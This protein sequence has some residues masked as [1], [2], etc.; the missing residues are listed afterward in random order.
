MQ[1]LRKAGRVTYRPLI[2]RRAAARSVACLLV[3]IAFLLA[4]P[5]GPTPD[6]SPGGR[7][8]VGLAFAASPLE[9]C[10]LDGYDDHNGA[11]LPWA[12]FD[13]TRGDTIP[14]G[15]DGVANSW[16]GEHT[17]DG[18]SA[19]TSGNGSAGTKKPTT[20]GS[21]DP[22]N[23]GG[24]DA[25][26]RSGGSGSTSDSQ[27]GS[28][29]P[30]SGAPVVIGSPV[31]AGVAAASIPTTATV[32]GVRGRILV[33]DADGA[34]VHAGG[35]LRITGE[36]FHPS[37]DGFEI[38]LDN[39]RLE[40]KASTD[41]G[42]RFEVFVTLPRDTVPGAHRIGVSY[43]GSHLAHAPVAVGAPP[44]DTFLGALLV[45]LDRGNRDRDAGLST[46]LGLGLVGAVSYGWRSF[47]RRPSPRRR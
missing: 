7:F 21:S 18:G 25:A 12:G 16:K 15:W 42:G 1:D 45:G 43:G 5:I 37:V 10:D 19:G 9:D 24:G 13:S 46:L 14:S 6:R 32:A 20:G 33:V 38:W 28:V 26:P 3:A 41:G 47:A 44:A 34:S 8:G 30:A 22:S 36:G 40:L 11:P 27:E 23:G 39:V 2:L 4:I 35:R 17:N 31:A 29:D